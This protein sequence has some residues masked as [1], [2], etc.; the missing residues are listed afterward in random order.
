MYLLSLMLI[1]AGLFIYVAHRG[2]YIVSYLTYTGFLYL[3]LLAIE[4][5]AKADPGDYSSPVVFMVFNTVIFLLHIPFIIRLSQFHPKEER[6]KKAREI[7]EKDV[8]H[9]HDDKLHKHLGHH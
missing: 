2:K 6:V 7:F 3:L 9:L 1:L 4:G 8:V 5:F